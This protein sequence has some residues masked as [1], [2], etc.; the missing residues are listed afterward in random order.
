MTKNEIPFSYKITFTN[1]LD[2]IAEKGKNLIWTILDLD[3]I[4][5]LNEGDKYTELLDQFHIGDQHKVFF[6]T[7]DEL[8]K[9][10]LK[11]ETL[12]AFIVVG[13]Q[14]KETILEVKKLF[15]EIP[16][17]PFVKNSP[18][19]YDIFVEVDDGSIFG[20]YSKNPEIEKKCLK[21][22]GPYPKPLVDF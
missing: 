3:I 5:D 15:R 11:I 2:Q 9:M 4:G 14:E 12:I 19:I 22:F 10:S 20:I 17:Y 21:K 16:G 18:K 8:Y 1:I 6:L 13:C 7:W